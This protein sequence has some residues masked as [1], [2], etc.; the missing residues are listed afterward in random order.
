MAERRLIQERFNKTT[1]FYTPEDSIINLINEHGGNFR[2]VTS[3]DGLINTIT[4][5]LTEQQEVDG[6]RDNA[7]IVKDMEKR[8]KYCEDNTIS[9]TV[10]ED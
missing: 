3:E 6:L 8:T 10:E 7:L 2:Q 9:F 1:P 4:I 5:T